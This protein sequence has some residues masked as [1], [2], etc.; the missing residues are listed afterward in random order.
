MITSPSAIAAKSRGTLIESGQAI[1]DEKG[2]TEL[3]FPLDRQVM[4]AEHGLLRDGHR[5]GL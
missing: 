5:G 3:E 2:R 1:L 4:T